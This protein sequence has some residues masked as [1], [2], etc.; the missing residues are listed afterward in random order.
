MTFHR[1]LFH[2]A[3][4]AT[5]SFFSHAAFL[6]S[7]FPSCCLVAAFTVQLPSMS[8][9]QASQGSGTSNPDGTPVTNPPANAPTNN[10]SAQK[11]P[12]PLTLDQAFELFDKLMEKSEERIRQSI[13][14][15]LPHTLLIRL[16]PSSAS[17]R[18]STTRG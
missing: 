14:T 12:E 9:E 10:A 1:H 13:A 5:H 15:T 7:S 16:P 8:T 11:P 18:T 2:S 6:L 3:L 4:P 17:P